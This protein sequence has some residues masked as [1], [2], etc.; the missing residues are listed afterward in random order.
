MNS[1]RIWARFSCVLTV[2]GCAG[3]LWT[4]DAS[5][6]AISVSG[7]ITWVTK[8]NAY[9]GTVR[10]VDTGTMTFHNTYSPVYTLKSF[11]SG[12]PA[13]AP[14]VAKEALDHEYYNFQ[15]SCSTDGA[16]THRESDVGAGSESFT[17][18]WWATGIG[19]RDQPP[20][21]YSFTPSASGYPGTWSGDVPA[22]ETDYACQ[23]PNT[24]TQWS[25]PGVQVY[26][27]PCPMSGLRPNKGKI[28]GS[29]V[30]QYQGSTT[31][32]SWN[33]DLTGKAVA[34]SPNVPTDPQSLH[35]YC[36]NRGEQ[37]GTAVGTGTAGWI[38]G[39]VRVSKT[40]EG[41]ATA[42][43]GAG[44]YFG[45]LGLLCTFIGTPKLDSP[46][47]AESACGALSSS[48]VVLG[49]GGLVGAFSGL[50]TIP[51]L[52]VSA[53]GFLDGVAGEFA[54]DHDPVDHNFHKLA[55]PTV[56]SIPIPATWKMSKRDHAALSFALQNAAAI[57]AYGAATSECIN[58][59]AGAK[60]ARA[61]TWMRAQYRCA[62]R[63]AAI[64]AGLF[65][66][67]AHGETALLADL[68]ADGVS[69]T[70]NASQ[71]AAGLAS[72]T[73]GAKLSAPGHELAVETLAANALSIAKEAITH[74]RGLQ[75]ARALKAAAKRY[76]ALAKQ[77]A[78]LA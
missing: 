64:L 47:Y 50:G 52:V 32:T 36:D 61:T 75:D 59:A 65:R 68:Q 42:L 72:S 20:Y 19:S 46:V 74:F 40:A 34:P 44:L 69:V 2:L 38:S 30:C 7:S 39:L 11:S 10:G 1:R 27:P 28:V 29:A 70:S 33:I 51:S 49:A 26:A 5:A 8:I 31:T 71:I 16:P 67:V 13:D 6:K 57:Y 43:D 62:A 73:T 56:R 3:V 66:T 23:G 58:R 45:G 22:T 48:A 60:A 78:R 15:D 9:G 55:H 41:A 53:A 4:A 63:Y 54:C 25:A 14:A 21:T 12:S 77:Y 76:S 37:A 24:V 18:Y 17:M 35:Q